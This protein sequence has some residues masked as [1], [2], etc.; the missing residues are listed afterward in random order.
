LRRRTS[1]GDGYPHLAVACTSS[2]STTNAGWVLFGDPKLNFATQ[3]EIPLLQSPESVAVGDFNGDGV[4]AKECCSYYIAVAI[5]SG[6][7]TFNAPKYTALRSDSGPAQLASGNFYGNGR[8]D[9]LVLE[10]FFVTGPDVVP[11]VFESKGD[12]TFSREEALSYSVETC[13][14]ADMNGDGNADIASTL[15]LDN[16]VA[17]FFG[18][19]TG[20]FSATLLNVSATTSSFAAADLNG[21]GFTDLVVNDCYDGSIAVLYGSG[22]GNFEPAAYFAANEPAFWVGIGNF[23][24]K[25]AADIAVLNDYQ[26]RKWPPGVHDDQE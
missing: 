10:R 9:L 8:Q 25:N 6:S 17:L 5:G 15:T 20:Q 2:D 13:I 18:S 3:L 26:N 23:I 16:Q 22:S 4:P 1:N 24:R 12:G 19:G 11:Y 14:V 7:G 21:D